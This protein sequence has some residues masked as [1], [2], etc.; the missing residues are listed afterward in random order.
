MWGAYP[1]A[2]D[3]NVGAVHSNPNPPFWTLSEKEPILEV[4]GL[5]VEIHTPKL[6]SE[7]TE[8]T[9]PSIASG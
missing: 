6:K 4:F 2:M 3:G 1:L 5:S 9:F 8:P 7:C